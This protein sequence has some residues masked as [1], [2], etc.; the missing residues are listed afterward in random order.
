MSWGSR[1][2]VS[3]VLSA[4]HSHSVENLLLTQDF[5]LIN[6]K[7]RLKDNLIIYNKG[8]SIRDA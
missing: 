2:I 1:V 5:W 4:I 3:I 8:G 6:K 7:M